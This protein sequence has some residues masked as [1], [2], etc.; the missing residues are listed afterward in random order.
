MS[1]V[2]V[3]V[4]FYVYFSFTYFI[5]LFLFYLCIFFYLFIYV[6]F[7]FFFLG[8]GG[9]GREWKFT[10]VVWIFCSFSISRSEIL[11]AKFTSMVHLHLTKL[12]YIGNSSKVNHMLMQADTQ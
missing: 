5:L 6:F 1:Q 2:F 8:G 12:L 3:V 9:G 4:G 11:F 7:F 10:Q